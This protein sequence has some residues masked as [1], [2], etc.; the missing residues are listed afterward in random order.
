[1]LVAQA[2]RAVEIFLDTKLDHAMAARVCNDIRIQ[3]ENIVLTGMP[4]SGK[5]TVGQS[6]AQ[7][8]GREFVEI[9]QEIVSAEGRSISRIF[10]ESGEAFFRDLETSVIRKICASHVGCVIATGGGAVLR[11][12]NLRALGRNGRIYFLDRPLEQLLPTP[13]RPLSSD[14]QALRR[15]YNERYDR[16]RTSCHVRIPNGGMPNEAVCAIREDFFK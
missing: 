6:L 4:G 13:D 11:D 16:Y 12:E 1:M 7:E 14:N 10:T 15:R 3:K 9:D 5:S 2:I 8:L